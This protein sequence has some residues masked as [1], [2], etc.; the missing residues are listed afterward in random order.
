MKILA[1]SDTHGFHEQLKIPEDIDVIIHGGDFSNYRDVARNTN[2]CSLFLNWYESL[3]I[4]HKIVIAGNHDTA[5]QA[6]AINPRDFKSLTYLEHEHH[7][8]N[9]IKFFGSPYTPSFGIGWAFNKDRSKLQAY[10]NEIED[11]TDVIITHGPPK[12]F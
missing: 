8:I 2:E 5:I 4:A 7:T 11:D 3:N 9:N 10:W 6:K 1:I 12:D